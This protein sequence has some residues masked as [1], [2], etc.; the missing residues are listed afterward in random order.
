MNRRSFFCRVGGLLAG[1]IS[2]R[3]LLA[4]EPNHQDIGILPVE[5]FNGE[6]L[7]YT[8]FC[9]DK[10]VANV[11]ALLLADSKEAAELFANA[12]QKSFVYPHNN[13]SGL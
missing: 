5:D 6:G 2:G 9:K 8:F 13:I 11:V 1:L 7:G 12:L 4:E 3:S 10:E